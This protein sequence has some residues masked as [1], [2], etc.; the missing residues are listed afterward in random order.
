MELLWLFV[1]FLPFLEGSLVGSQGR[2]NNG[3][4]TQQAKRLYLNGRTF[5]QYSEAIFVPG[6]GGT[7]LYKP[8]RYVPPQRVGLFFAALVWNGYRLCRLRSFWSGIGHGF[9]GNCG[10]VWTYLLFQF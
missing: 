3:A 2:Q 6:V 7:P 10:S 4:K 5:I 9:Q 8:Y 1:N